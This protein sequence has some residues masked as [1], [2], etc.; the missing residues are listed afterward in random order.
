[1][2]GHTDSDMDAIDHF[3]CEICITY[4]LAMAG[5]LAIN[6]KVTLIPLPFSPQRTKRRHHRHPPGSV[7]M[8]LVCCVV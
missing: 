5:D 2:G 7:V 3:D 1:M 6:P 4:A 8:S